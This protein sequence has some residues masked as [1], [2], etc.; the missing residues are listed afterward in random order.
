MKAA[1]HC[2]SDLIVQ[3]FGPAQLVR[4]NSAVHGESYLIALIAQQ[5]VPVQL[6]SIKAAV[7]C[8]SDLM[9]QQFRPE[10][11]AGILTKRIIDRV[12]FDFSMLQLKLL[13]EFLKLIPM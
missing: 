1:V 13:L 5:F 8:E 3:Q 7:Q 12:M 4:I 6:A 10:Q 11:L 9:V 2:V